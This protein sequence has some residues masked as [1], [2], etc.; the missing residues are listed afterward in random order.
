MQ[1]I[2]SDLD[3]QSFFDTRRLHFAISEQDPAFPAHMREI[4]L[5]G[6]KILLDPGIASFT[7]TLSHLG[8]QRFK[9]VSGQ[10]VEFCSYVSTI[11]I[12]SGNMTD[13]KSFIGQNKE[14]IH[15]LSPF[16]EWVLTA[17]NSVSSANLQ[18]LETFTVTFSGNYRASNT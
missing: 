13:F 6:F 1:V 14:T 9:T 15:G 8:R 2:L 11:G 17:D 18:K 3:R 12:E 16:S 5:T 4:F 10:T 7:G